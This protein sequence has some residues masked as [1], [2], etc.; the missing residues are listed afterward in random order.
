MLAVGEVCERRLYL[1]EPTPEPYSDL[2]RLTHCEITPYSLKSPSSRFTHSHIKSRPFL[3]VL[4]Y[5]LTYFSYA[6]EKKTVF[7]SL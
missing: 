5:I 4:I 7:K 6:L 3:F 2:P 1:S